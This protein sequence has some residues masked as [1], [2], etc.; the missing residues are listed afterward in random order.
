MNNWLLTVGTCDIGDRGS[1]L[2]S[3]QGLV[4]DSRVLSVF[5]GGSIGLVRS[6]FDEESS[7]VREN[8]RVGSADLL[9]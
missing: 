5:S 9:P 1:A 8:E 3:K 7:T 2:R 4:G 6:R